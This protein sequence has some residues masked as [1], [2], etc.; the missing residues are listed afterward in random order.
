M[1]KF[2]FLCVFIIFCMGVCTSASYHQ[3]I[4]E[5]QI[6]KSIARYFEIEQF[7][8]DVIERREENTLEQIYNEHIV[9]LKQNLFQNVIDRIR[10]NVGLELAN[11]LR[12]LNETTTMVYGILKAGDY[13]GLNRF[14]HSIRLWNV[15]SMLETVMQCGFSRE[16]WMDISDVSSAIDRVEVGTVDMITMFRRIQNFANNILH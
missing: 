6:N 8:W 14:S 5:L 9:M 3:P 11:G 15:T 10:I 16:L 4:E 2:G 12:F 7:L 13:G 1:D